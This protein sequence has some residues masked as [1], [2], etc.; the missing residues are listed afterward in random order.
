MS[1]SL[2]KQV[3]D[4]IITERWEYD[5]EIK[6]NTS[7]QND[8]KIYGDDASDILYKFCKKFKVDYTN[9]QFD[10]YFRPELSWTDFFKKKKKYK[11]FTVDDLVKAIDRKKLE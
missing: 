5:F 2:F 7:L 3:K 6:R 8:L 9:F 1:N 4:F 11:E 10:N